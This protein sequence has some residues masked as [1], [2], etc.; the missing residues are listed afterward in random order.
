VA[1]EAPYTWKADL[2]CQL[3]LSLDT[4]EYE[5]VDPEMKAKAVAHCD[6]PA[7]LAQGLAARTPCCRVL[8]VAVMAD[9]NAKNLCC[10][11]QRNLGTASVIPRL[12]TT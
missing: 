1:F 4:D 8:E 6:I 3:G 10:A 11:P 5:E 12:A 9:S 2:I 7:V